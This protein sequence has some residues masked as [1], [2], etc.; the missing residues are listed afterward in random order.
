MAKMTA[1][2]AEKINRAHKLG[3]GIG[4]CV[5]DTTFHFR[6][7]VLNKAEAPGRLLLQFDWEEPDE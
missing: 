6:E 4:L 7:Q 3:Y 5:D 2:M 1:A